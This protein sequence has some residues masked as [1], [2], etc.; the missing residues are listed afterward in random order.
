[1]TWVNS[2]KFS[3]TQGC[4]FKQCDQRSQKVKVFFRKI[5][6]WRK[7]FHGNT[8][9]ERVWPLL[10]KTR[11]LLSR[12]SL[13]SFW[14]SLYPTSFVDLLIRPLESIFLKSLLN[15]TWSLQKLRKSTKLKGSHR[16]KASVLLLSFPLS[17]LYLTHI[18]I[19]ILF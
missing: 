9:Q 19:Q 6:V 5:T 8:T 17:L 11:K 15:K 13:S 18:S 4:T 3:K 16:N 12:P 2:L 10:I 7:C 14:P 1:M